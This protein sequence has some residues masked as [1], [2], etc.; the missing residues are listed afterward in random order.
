MSET[1]AF[2][3]Q[4]ATINGLRY[5]YVR[6]GSGPPLFLIHG[7]PGFHYEWH[8][9]IKPLAERFDV[10]VPD[11][12]GYG[13]TEVPDL[14]PEEA[15]TDDV[16]AED[17]RALVEHL[18]FDKVSIVSHD[19]GSVWTRRFARTY[20]DLVDKL[21][22][23]Q[24][25]YPGIGARFFTPDRLPETWYMFFHQLPLAEQLVGSSRQ[26]TEVYLRHFLSHWSYDK[27]LWA[28]DEVEQYVD[29]F[30][31]PGT[32]RGGFN[33]YRAMFRTLGRPDP[34][35]PQIHAP[36]LVLWAENDPIF[37]VA[38]S[39]KLPDFFPN[40][41]LRTVPD[42]GHWVQREQP[43]LVNREITEFILGSPTK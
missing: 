19:F 30:S 17:L 36:T 37:P 42:C 18:G 22:L 14:P 26:A 4:Y 10:I 31:Q 2:N 23:F 43:E 32:L 34:G 13:H 25:V 21:V 39:D 9:N 11:M 41:T 20:P 29:V 35:D 15:Y 24:P 38:W 5:H 40:L 8:L 3:H 27:S 6:E 1:E 16:F 7:W 28:A 33:C 12:R